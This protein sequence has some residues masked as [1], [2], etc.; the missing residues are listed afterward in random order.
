MT[1]L[2]PGKHD[3]FGLVGSLGRANKKN[4][5]G[6]LLNRKNV[7]ILPAFYC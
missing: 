4:V 2:I 1:A 7:P 6:D 5:C 3:K